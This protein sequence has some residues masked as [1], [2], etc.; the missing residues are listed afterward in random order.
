MSVPGW[1]ILNVYVAIINEIYQ[2][3][4]CLLEQ[5]CRDLEANKDRFPKKMFVNVNLSQVDFQ[6]VN[7]PEEVDKIVS[8]YQISKKQIQFEIM[9][10]AFAD[11]GLLQ[12]AVRNL[13]AALVCAA[14]GR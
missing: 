4:L 2:L 10:S 8:R 5:V 7:I 3:D 6:L 9:E 14:V 11:Q 13:G 1:F 12:D